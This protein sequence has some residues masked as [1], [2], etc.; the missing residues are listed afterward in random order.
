VRAVRIEAARA[1]AAIPTGDLDEKQQVLLEQGIQEYINAQLAMA[2]RPEAQA[3]LGSLYGARGEMDKALAAF[4]TAIDLNP[5]YV[6][7][8]VNL[9]DLYR[10]QEDERKADSVLRRALK[11]APE[12][13]AVHHA[14]GLSLIRQQRTDEAVN[15]LQQ[16]ATLNPN[17]MRYVYVYAVALN[18]TGK[19]EQAVMVLQGAHNSQPDNVDILN[20]LVAFHRDMGNQ[21][22]ARN[23]A[24]KLRSISP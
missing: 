1:L 19:P 22:A 23:Y 15:E 16:A 11:I 8:Y 9:A 14:L 10:T 6:P 18:S 7:A 5:A 20:A 21:A 4:N 2:E 13:A 24:E 17:N 12:S 3:N